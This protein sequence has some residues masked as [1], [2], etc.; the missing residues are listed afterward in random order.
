MTDRA[1]RRE[2]RRP[3]VVQRQT[4]ACTEERAMAVAVRDRLPLLRRA[5]RVLSRGDW[6]LAED[7]VQEAIIELWD[8]D[9]S[10]YAAED[11]RLLRKILFDEMKIVRLRDRRD[12]GGDM[13]VEG[14]LEEMEEDEGE[15]GPSEE[16]KRALDPEEE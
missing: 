14:N 16:M 1:V 8:R 9:P 2:P 13:R 6:Q 12:R 7:M 5:A 4:R 3:A 11:E 10:R 15:L